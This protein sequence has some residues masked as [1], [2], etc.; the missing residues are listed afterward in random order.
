MTYYE[1]YTGWIPT[2][3][4]EQKA[5]EKML[6]RSQGSPEFADLAPHLKNYGADKKLATPY[7]SVLHFY[8]K[9]F[10]DESQTTGDCKLIAA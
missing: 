8:P 10:E 7:K 3:V 9:A 6:S 5:V 2:P 4:N 1:G